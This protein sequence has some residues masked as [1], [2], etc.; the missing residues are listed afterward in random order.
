MIENLPDTQIAVS[1]LAYRADAETP[2]ARGLTLEDYN[3][4]IR[5]LSERYSLR[6]VDVYANG[7]I[8]RRNFAALSAD[9]AHLNDD[10][11]QRLAGFF[12]EC[13]QLDRCD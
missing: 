1:T 12:I 6:L 2:N 4:A 8:D 10:G 7:G 13:L 9:D 3:G 11:H 5:H